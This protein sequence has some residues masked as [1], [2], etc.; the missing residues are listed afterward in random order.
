MSEALQSVV[1]RIDKAQG[2]FI[3]QDYGGWY[4]N[5]AKPFADSYGDII[6]GKMSA[7]DAGELQ[8]R[9]AKEARDDTIVTKYTRTDCG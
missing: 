5:V 3:R 2:L 7:K 9:A 6:W 8:E 1:E 4:P